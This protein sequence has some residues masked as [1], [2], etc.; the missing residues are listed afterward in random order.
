MYRESRCL[1]AEC[2]N[3]LGTDWKKI[4]WGCGSTVGASLEQED[5]PLKVM[6]RP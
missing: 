2:V 4:L 5:R 3:G 6:D 1:L